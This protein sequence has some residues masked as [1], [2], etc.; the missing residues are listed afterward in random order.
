MADKKFMSL[1][2]YSKEFVKSGEKNFYDF[3]ERKRQEA[4]GTGDQELANHI[5]TIYNQAYKDEERYY[6]DL[7]EED[8]RKKKDKFVTKLKVDSREVNNV[9][10]KDNFLK[11]IEGN[12][13]K[14]NMLSIDRLK[15]L[16][17]YYDSVIEENDRK[18]KKLKA[19]A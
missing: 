8:E 9:V 6:E 11:E 4:L 5:Q 16:E 19:T 10:K 17:K 7:Q 2:E 15:K 14:L 3:L 18:I 1:D 13:E 12:P